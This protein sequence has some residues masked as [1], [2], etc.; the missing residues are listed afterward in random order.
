MG[1]IKM[2]FEDWSP[3]SNV[4]MRSFKGSS[5]HLYR[6][7]YKRKCCDSRYSWHVYANNQVDAQTAFQYYFMNDKDIAG[8]IV[9]G[10]LGKVKIE[11]QVITSGDGIK[12]NNG[13]NVFPTAPFETPEATVYRLVSQSL[14]LRRGE[15]WTFFCK[16]V[17]RIV[18]S[19]VAY[20]L[21]N[22]GLHTFVVSS[23]ST[24]EIICNAFSRWLTGG[25]IG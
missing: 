9:I 18:M 12:Q 2:G 4:S 8:I 1:E 10:D 23:P 5:A 13:M 15:N 19:I 3:E 14:N 21:I 6:V 7:D 24:L 22:W 25:K 17:G 11:D 16:V 20:I